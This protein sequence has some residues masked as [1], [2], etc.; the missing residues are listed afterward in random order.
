MISASFIPTPS[1]GDVYGTDF[2]FIDTTSS[3]NVVVKRIWDFGDNTPRVYNTLTPIHSYSYPGTYTV[4]VTAFD[5][6]GN[7]SIASN[8]VEVDYV[9]RDYITFTSLPEDYSVPGQPTSTPFKIS[10]TSAQINTPIF[11]DLYAAGSQTTPFETVPEKWRFLTPTWRFLDKNLTPVTSLSVAIENIY[12][13]GK[14]VAVSGTSEFYYVDDKCSGSTSAPET[15]C[16]ILITATLQTSGFSSPFDSK[17]FDYPSY[18]NNNTIRTGV[19][20]NVYSVI[21]THL[22]ITGNYLE[23][24]YPYKWSN[25]KIPFLTTI[26]SNKKNYLQ[27]SEEIESGVLFTLPLTNSLGNLA[28]VIARLSGTDQYIVD[29]APLYFQA[30][31]KNGFDSGGYLFTTLTPTSTID[32]T[33]IAVSST[34]LLNQESNIG[35]FAYPLGCSPNVFAWISNPSNKTLHKVF[36]PPYPNTCDTINSFKV[37]DSLIDGYIKTIDV[38]GISS[39]NTFNYYMSGFAGIY[40]M[41]IDPRQHDLF[42]TD[43]ELDRIYKFSNNGTL[44]SSIELSAIEGIPSILQAYTPSNICIDG[45]YNIYVSLFNTVSVLKF[46]EDLNYLFTLLPTIETYNITDGDFIYKPA[47]VE[48]DRENNVWVSYSNPIS[49]VLIK[50]DGTTGTPL[51]TIPQ[52]GSSSVSLAI[53]VDNNLW[54]AN[55]LNTTLDEGELRLYS[56][57][58]TLMSS[59]LGYTHPGYLSV[60]KYDN[61][62]FIY[63]IRKIGYISKNNNLLTT[64]TSAFFSWPTYGWEIQSDGSLITDISGSSVMNKSITALQDFDTLNLTENRTKYDKD[65]ELGGLAIDV[66][67]RLWV[68]DSLDNKIFTF[69]TL[70]P[71]E[72]DI[73]DNSRIIKIYPDSLIGYYLNN[74]TTFTYTLTSEYNKS[75]QANGDWT[76]N[77]WYQKYFDPTALTAIPVSGIST[78]FSVNNFINSGQI[79][80]VNEN[81]NTAA[82]YKELALPEVLSRNTIFFDTFLGAVVGNNELSGTD[83][84]GRVVYERIANFI[85]THGDVDTCDIRQLLSY[86]EETDT[87]AFDYGT[88]FPPEIQKYLNITSTPR[89]K[90]YGFK[91]PLPNLILSRGPQ[92]TTTSI[93]V[94]A[95]DKIFLQNRADGNDVNLITLPTLNGQTIYPLSSLELPGFAQPLTAFYR[96]LSFDPVYSEK[97][98]ENYIDWNNPQTTLSPYISTEEDLYGDKGIIENTFNYLLTKNIV[99]K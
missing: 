60:D 50:Y 73:G 8:I 64:P 95:G 81:F 17:V 19:I 94:T 33:S 29:E 68:I 22:K 31:D 76:G 65:E 51:I 86:A 87:Y 99:V 71:E 93:I 35:Q 37:S 75:I 90:L 67:N 4:T 54:V 40:G 23:N 53:T 47:M 97:F 20:W 27:G 96:F 56:S 43:A 2:T 12:K 36:L 3:V 26:H 52:N 77:R 45:L 6:T 69:Q 98:I 11:I 44:L 92:I 70:E 15:K 91:S 18:A 82:H 84:I 25:V 24:I 62:W 39:T 79:R 16:P 30:T 10:L 80:L 55:S 34:I 72:T 61:L 78:P 14:V 7:S 66:F 74:A 21:P 63:N 41:A 48:T 1:S 88:D 5:I 38:P 85:S 46:D 13:N 28:P 42:A 59:V 83:D 32:S 57:T 9:Y 49:S 89:H 58:G